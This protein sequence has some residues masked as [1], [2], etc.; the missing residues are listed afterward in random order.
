MEPVTVNRPVSGGDSVQVAPTSVAQ[1]T[2]T[3]PV[4]GGRFVASETTGATGAAAGAGAGT[5]MTISAG[6]TAGGSSGGG[7]G[8]SPAKGL[9]RPPNG[10]RYP[11]AG[12]QP[13]DPPGT[14]GSI[15][16]GE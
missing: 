4:S 12:A 13:G 8:G 2:P 16:V 3:S 14:P 1:G 11:A 15:G 6:G 9:T 5:W 7:K 10:G